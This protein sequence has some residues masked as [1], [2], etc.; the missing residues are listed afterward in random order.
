[1]RLEELGQLKKKIIHVI[2]SRARDLWE[3]CTVYIFWA[4]GYA[5][6]KLR[7]KRAKSMM[8]ACFHSAD[9]A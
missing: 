3:E 2:G 4:K 9:T 8:K 7:P 1:M 6:K 5:N